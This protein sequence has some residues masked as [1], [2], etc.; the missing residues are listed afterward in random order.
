M[1]GGRRSIHGDVSHGRVS[2]P[3]WGANEGIHVNG[4]DR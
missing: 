2:T 4:F 1:M 3:T